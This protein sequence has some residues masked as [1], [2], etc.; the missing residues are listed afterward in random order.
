MLRATVLRLGDREH[1][2]QLVAHH[3]AVDGWSRGILNREL[4]T[5]Y[6]D[7]LSGS[8][9]MLPELPIQYADYAAWQ[10]DEARSSELNRELAY[11]RTKLE[12]L[13]LAIE[14]PASPQRQTV[15]A[16]TGGQVP[17]SI[18]EGLAIGIRQLATTM[19]VTPF[20]ILASAVMAT[21]HRYTGGVDIAIG[22]PI[23]GRTRVETENL[24]GLFVNT[25]VLRGDLS[26]QPSFTEV[27]QRVKGVCLEAF[28]H[29]ETPFERIVSEVG[30]ERIK[31]RPPVVQVMLAYQNLPSEPVSL[32]GTVATQIDVS[33]DTSKF[34]LSF[35]F[36]ETPQ[37]IAGRLVFSLQLFN[38]DRMHD[39]AGHFVRLLETGVE[40][41]EQSIGKMSMLSPIERKRILVD[42]NAATAP[43][44]QETTVHGLFERAAAAAPHSTAVICGNTSLTYGDLNDRANQVASCLRKLGV[45]PD[46]L[47][48]ISMHRSADLIVGL[49]GI[50]KA[51]AAY[52][53]L[54]HRFPPERLRF[55]M[56]DA[57]IRALVTQNNLAANL[58]TDRIETLRLDD[59]W[60]AIAQLEPV[61]SSRSQPEHLAYVMYTSGSTGK[62]KG[63][64]VSHRSLVG[65]L[66]AF[67]LV[68][69]ASPKRISTNVITYAF[70]TS[71]Q[72][73]FSP[74]CYGG[75]LHI[76][77]YEITLDGH[78]LARYLLD[79]GIN[80]AYCVPDLLP[81]VA[82]TFEKHGGCG[83]LA[84]LITG[85]AP[86][87]QKLLQRF[88]DISSTLRI[89]NTYG[90][91]E[92]TYGATAYEF[93]YAIAPERDVP[94]G[95]PHP[96]YQVYIVN[97]MLEPVPIGVTGEILIGGVGVSRG[98]LNRPDLTA[99]RFIP[100]PFSR[101][102]EDRLYKTGDLGRYLDDGIIEF[103]GRTDSQVKLRGYRI[104]L[105]EVELAIETYPLVEACH[106]S[107][108]QFEEGD[109]RLVAYVVCKHDKPLDA[110]ALREH[111]RQQLPG[112]MI[113]S[114]FVRLDSFPLLP[115]GKIDTRALP[116]PVFG[117]DPTA[118]AYLPPASGTEKKLARIW[119]DV[120]KL[121]R[122]GITD[123]F[124]ELGGHS[125]LATRVLSRIEETLGVHV[126]FHVLF[127]RPSIAAVAKFV[128]T[129]TPDRDSV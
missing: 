70:D 98:Y 41:P 5:I 12:G 21:L 19:N 1:V 112:Y 22:I 45:Q 78:G 101:D 53:P 44:P 32:V 24:V 61:R 43:G 2:I 60:S 33:T 26:G 129:A 83:E 100:N 118:E 54:D 39:L 69:D 123:N 117:R 71:V 96:D 14:L 36:W 66:N 81:S 27:L 11:W 89:L 113:P 52:L 62:P 103:L 28:D 104:D 85:L 73:I 75:T 42:W 17:L 63:V 124:F 49:L 125:L 77:P 4:A 76:V 72:E 34:D 86:M 46:E 90:P 13:P 94:I 111:L 126:P 116:P 40:E 16:F 119:Q 58:P 50:L 121:D 68:V 128:D 84:C 87:K 35:D 127:E 67:R 23:A 18:S 20:M 91:T 109:A 97:D 51:G 114:A 9:P 30:P 115:S 15:K 95:R 56:E 88:R 122:V 105:R 82:E 107:V 74:L 37:G 31:D 48:G 10:R 64:M 93:E 8:T 102:P 99:A 57:S 106:S 47:V 7:L 110:Q 3:I 38:N 25:L 80:T 108:A 92:V 79:H 120:L 55:M 6:R 65:F 29:Q 59:D